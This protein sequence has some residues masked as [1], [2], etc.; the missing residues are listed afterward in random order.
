MA[1]SDQA[2]QEVMRS[3]FERVQNPEHWKG[4]VDAMVAYSEGFHIETIRDAVM[5][6]TATEA[7]ITDAGS[8]R[9]H[10]TA[11][12]YWQGPAN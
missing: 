7:E 8:G 4:P 1:I 2:Y 12:G 5:F 11:P 9:M 6:F 10:V 3:T